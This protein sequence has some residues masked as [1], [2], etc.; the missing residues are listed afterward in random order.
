VKPSAIGDML[1]RAGWQL[2]E[3][4]E[5]TPAYDRWYE[6][7]V[8]RMD[9]KRARIIDSVGAE[10]FAFVRGQYTGLL[11]AIRDGTLGG[12]IIHARGC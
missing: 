12:A 9:R 7:L 3:I 6:S 10:G 5:L 4:E 11:A 1:R 8:Q 2:L